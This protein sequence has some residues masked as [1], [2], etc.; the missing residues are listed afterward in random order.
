MAGQAAVAERDVPAQ[1]EPAESADVSEMT[2]RCGGM[3]ATEPPCAVSKAA[4]GR[5]GRLR[6][7]RCSAG[8]VACQ[9]DDGACSCMR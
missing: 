1:A 4:C 3:V 8:G 5:G 7:E 2:R 9:S 6:C